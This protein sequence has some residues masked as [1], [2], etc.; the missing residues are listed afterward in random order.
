MPSDLPDFAKQ[1]WPL[2]EPPQGGPPTR[3]QQPDALTQKI[4]ETHQGVQNLQALLEQ[5]EADAPSKID[6]MVDLLETI[7]GQ[8]KS[9][10]EN[11]TLLFYRQNEM[12][13]AM[14]MR[15]PPPP[16]ARQDG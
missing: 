1:P 14:A 5:P 4:G 13:R 7:A 9:L 12:F 6:I 8:Q 10:A 2:P 15:I 3:P 11:L 16:Q